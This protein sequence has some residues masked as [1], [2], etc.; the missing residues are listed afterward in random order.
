VPRS[1]GRSQRI[2]PSILRPL[3]PWA[4]PLP[5][6]DSFLTGPVANGLGQISLIRRSCD[7]AD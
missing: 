7:Q 4:D 5:A 1:R 2:R 3:F 6:S